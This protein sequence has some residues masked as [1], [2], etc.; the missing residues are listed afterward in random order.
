MPPV[1]QRSRSRRTPHPVPGILLALLLAAACLPAPLPATWTPVPTAVPLRSAWGEVFTIADAQQMDAP[2]LQAVEGGLAATWI[3]A[4]ASGVH[5][6]AR[7]IG[8]FGP[9]AVVVL[10]LPP[11]RPRTQRLLSA[12]TRGLHLLW[13]DA[14]FDPPPDTLGQ[15]RLLLAFVD[16][17]LTVQ[18]GPL[19]VSEQV[20]LNYDVVSNADGSLWVAWSGGLLAEPT[21]SIRYIDNLGRPQPAI[22]LQRDADYPA[23]ARAADGTLH[24][25]WRR[26]SDGHFFMAQVQDGVLLNTREISGA[27]LLAAA[28]RLVSVR[29]A[30]DRTHGYVFVTLRRASGSVETWLIGGALASEVWN[31]PRRMGILPTETALPGTQSG[32]YVA[33]WG[34]RWLGWAVPL[35][36]PQTVPQEYVM[37]AAQV[38]DSLALVYLRGAAVTGYEP[39]VEDVRLIG[40]PSA[41][42]M[43]GGGLALAWAQP[44]ADGSAR[45][46]LTQ[47]P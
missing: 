20:A 17:R 39:V 14:L 5:Q 16:Q 9:S 8:E 27:L 25:F 6:D 36:A 4:D 11:V 42:A 33:S 35:T 15:T 40:F 44:T 28:D 21:L 43:D 26:A 46:Y 1:R 32:R 24:V 29:A 2:A 10:P 37:L 13:L 47:R 3:G 18:R 31:L 19:D 7:T 45:L 30:L 12:G 38:G 41:V 23:L 34:D 22:L